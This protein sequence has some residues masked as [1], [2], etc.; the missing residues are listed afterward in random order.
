MVI[1]F[2]G[3]SKKVSG[4]G[5]SS[6]GKASANPQTE[7]VKSE[8]YIGPSGRMY[9]FTAGISVDVPAND[10]Q[11]FLSFKSAGKPEFEIA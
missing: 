6:C 9:N 10:A 5:C 11:Y 7:F 2:L 8:T 4:K 3:K 1:K